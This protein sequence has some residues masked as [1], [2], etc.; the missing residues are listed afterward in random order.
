LLIE[1]IRLRKLNNPITLFS[2]YSEVEDWLKDQWAGL[3][4][5]LIH[6]LTTTQQ[7]QGID[8]K[9]EELAETTETLKRYLEEVVAR[10]SLQKADAS[11]IIKQ[12]NERLKEA[13]RDAEFLSIGYIKH[14]NR[15]HDLSVA[16]LRKSV[17]QSENY[18]SFVKAVFPV[19]AEGCF[20]SARAFREVNEARQQ[21]ELP[22]YD[23]K[24][25][26]SI[27]DEFEK[28]RAAKEQESTERT[29]Y[30]DGKKRRPT[31]LS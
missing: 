14:L 30:P 6:R 9:V 21:F 17:Q 5:E 15:H 26:D 3:F 28:T 7:I 13:K 23:Q 1:D 8:T 11:E 19:E 18:K 25:F 12:E 22:P 31:D 20:A 4:R 24:E 27:R 16:E 29:A 2:K 10:V